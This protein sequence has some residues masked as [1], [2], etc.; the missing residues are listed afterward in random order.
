MRKVN[1][2]ILIATVD[3]RMGMSFNHRRVSQDKTVLEKILAITQGKVLWMN[4]YSSKLFGLEH[5][6][7]N[8]DDNF[9]REAAAG[10]YCL[11]ETDDPVT[12]ETWTEQIIL[13]RWNRK[14]PAD[15]HFSIDLNKWKLVSTEEFKGNS[16]DKI[17]MEV[18]H[19][20]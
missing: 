1:F 3:N 20:N 2:M 5:Q 12:A 19:A 10:E 16:H 4:S 9:L 6:Q 8:V 14:Y 11:A 7:I 18:Y 17:T 13:F 15:T